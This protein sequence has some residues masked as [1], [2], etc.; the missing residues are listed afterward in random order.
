[1]CP[2]DALHGRLRDQP[3]DGSPGPP[4]TGLAVRAVATPARRLPRPR[5][6]RRR[7]STR[8]PGLP[9]MVFA[10][11]GAI[12]VDGIVLRRPVPL[13]AARRR[14][15]RLRDMVPRAAATHV[16]DAGARQRGRGRLARRRRRD[17]RRHRLPHRPARR[18]PRPHELFGRAGRLARAGRPALLPPRHRAGRARPPTTRSRTTRRRSRRGRAGVLQQRFPD[19]VIATADDAA[20]LGLNAVSDGRARG[21]CPARADLGG[22]PRWPSAA[23][24][25]SPSTC[26]SCS[27]AAAASSAARS[28]CASAHA[29]AA[30][31]SSPDGVP[32]RPRSVTR[33]TTTTRCPSSSPT[34][35]GAWVT[36]VDGRRY[37]DCLSG[38]SAL[39]FGH[40]PPAP[41]RGRARAARPPHA[42]QPRVRQRP[43]R[44]VL[45]RRSP[46]LLGKEMVLPMN[47]GAEAVETAI[48]VARKWGYQV[49]GVAGRPGHDHR[50]W[51]ATSTA[52]RRRSSAFSTD[53]D[54]PR[55]LRPVH[56]G[57][58]AR[59]RTATPTALRGRDRRRPPSPC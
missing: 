23:S 26:P 34:G 4:T 30:E 32:R 10:A 53:P 31:S 18:T 17:P 57:L 8:C 51:R 2:P 40:R 20:V 22:P 19:A 56:A 6:H 41:G 47:T 33:R 7:R 29:I 27:R 14:G 25:P 38:Y 1:M 43:A 48:K 42:D 54:A 39:N 24:T 3:V 13:P 49:K 15:P 52:A 12:V 28:S 5:P 37:L 50:R 55:R 16:V 11:N 21:R 46:S 36:D 44:A 45:P 9:D 35:E 59:A 58:P